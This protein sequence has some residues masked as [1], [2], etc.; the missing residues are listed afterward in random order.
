MV[1][2]VLVLPLALLMAG[3]PLAAATAIDAGEFPRT[4]S[5]LV[6]Q[7]GKIAYE[8]HFGGT[9]AAT[10]HDPRSASKSITALAVGMAI[11]EKKIVSVDAPAFAFLSDLGPFAHDGPLKAGITVGDLLTMSSA[12]DCD[13]DDGRSPGNED[14]M[15]PLQVWARWAVD[16]PV[17]AGYTR[18]ASHRGPW[19]YCTAGVLLLGQILQRATGERVD[20]YIERHLLAPLGVGQVEWKRSPAGE[21]MTGGMLRMTTGDLARVGRMVLDH[22]RWGGKQ[23]VPA[24]WIDQALSAQR[25]PNASADPRH[26]HDYGYLFWRRDYPTS[27]G[28][29]SGWFMSGNGGNHVVMLRDLD[30]VVVVTTVNYNTRGMHAQTTRLVER[31]IAPL[32]CSARERR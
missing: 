10:L 30:A 29:S 18:D 23:V 5:V 27:C 1:A 28:R 8:R 6:E 3:D 12:L 2:S 4:T 19:S 22:G 25:K 26:E 15:Y 14:N 9:S 13:D 11:A 16:L 21:V 7:A 31:L 32:R 24:A 17:K 20:R